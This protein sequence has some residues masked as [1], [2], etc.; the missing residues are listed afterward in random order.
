MGRGRPIPVRNPGRALPRPHSTLGCY[1]VR[2]CICLGHILTFIPLQT[3]SEASC[4]A[5]P[6]TPKKGAPATKK[7]SCTK[8][9]TK[10]KRKEVPK[11]DEDEATPS[12]K[13]KTEPDDED[14]SK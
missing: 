1:S 12:K 2:H 10:R 3:A 13:A 4:S 7:T 11:V 5:T 8:S 14:E 9:A 6:K